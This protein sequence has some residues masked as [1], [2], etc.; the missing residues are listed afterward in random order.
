M[1]RLSLFS[2]WQHWGKQQATVSGLTHGQ[3]SSFDAQQ[4]SRKAWKSLCRVSSGQL[5]PAAYTRHLRWAGR[6]QDVHLHSWLLRTSQ[7]CHAVTSVLCT[8]VCGCPQHDRSIS[9][10]EP[11]SSWQEHTTHRKSVIYN[12]VTRGYSSAVQGD[13]QVVTDPLPT[14]PLK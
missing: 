12:P 9:P 13:C 8:C 3:K 4:G 7:L 14:S 6:S 2:L 1:A 11:C 10:E 5:D